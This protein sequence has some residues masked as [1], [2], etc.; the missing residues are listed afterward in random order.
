MATTAGPPSHH[1]SLSHV[2]NKYEIPGRSKI[3]QLEPWGINH[4]K[5]WGLEV[6]GVTFRQYGTR[7]KCANPYILILYGPYRD[8]NNRNILYSDE[9]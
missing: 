8:V 5:K 7:E 1:D 9:V 6:F 4:E 2:A 3:T